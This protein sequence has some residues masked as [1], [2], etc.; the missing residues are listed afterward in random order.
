MVQN[1][2]VTVGGVFANAGVANSVGS[3]A[4]FNAPL[5]NRGVPARFGL[6]PPFRPVVCPLAVTPA[7]P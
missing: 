4:T 5:I 7:R 6:K 3:V 2:S 1:N